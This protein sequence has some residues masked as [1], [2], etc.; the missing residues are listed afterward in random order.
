MRASTDRIITSHAGSLPRPDDLIEATRA[1]ESG[2]SIDENEFQQKL[3]AAVGDFTHSVALINACKPW[4]WRDKFPPSN[5]PSPQIARK[6]KE[7]FGW[8]LDGKK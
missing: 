6:A 2:G 1:R 4:H 7:K 5:A 3:R 8:L